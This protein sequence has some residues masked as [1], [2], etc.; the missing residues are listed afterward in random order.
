MAAETMLI[1]QA[2]VCA[3]GAVYWA[4]V[5]VQAVR[6]RRRTGR[7]ANV[8]P[9]GGK[10]W[11][12]WA[13]W[14]AVIA[15]W[16]GQPLAM[17]PFAGVPLLRPAEALLC[18]AGLVAGLALI[19]CGHA[20]TFWCYAALGDNWRMGTRG[21]DRPTL[22]TSG[23]YAAVRHPLYSFQLLLLLAAACLLPTVLSLL[24][25]TM[26]G[27]CC[28]VKA[29]DEEARLAEALGQPYADYRRRTGR[30]LPKLRRR[31]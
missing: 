18:G 4:A 26:G 16:I 3:S 25:L 21:R 24:A 13:G 2:A 5:L 27:L 9:R 19:A 1:R 8:G 30:F 7:S 12:L 31:A 14:S 23:P 20:G 28:V 10:E 22:V 17:G 15:V 6:V 29:L 11:A